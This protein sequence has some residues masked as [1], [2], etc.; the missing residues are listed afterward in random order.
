MGRVA[1][2]VCTRVTTTRMY[3]YREGEGAMHNA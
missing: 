1:E 3:K 2:A